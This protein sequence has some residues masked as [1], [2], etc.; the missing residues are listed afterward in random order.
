MGIRANANDIGTAS[1]VMAT[2]ARMRMLTN[3]PAVSTEAARFRT[4]G[5]AAPAFTFTGDACDNAAQ[6]RGPR[7]IG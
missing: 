1:R 7:G 3:I 2:D 5:D 4:N 6:V